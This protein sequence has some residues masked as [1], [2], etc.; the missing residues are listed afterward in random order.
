M[1]AR[2]HAS[3]CAVDKSFEKFDS[4][5]SI[6]QINSLENLKTSWFECGTQFAKLWN[7]CA[8]SCCLTFFFWQSWF[9]SWDG[10]LETIFEAPPAISDGKLHQKLINS[11]ILRGIAFSGSDAD[12]EGYLWRPRDGWWRS[13]SELVGGW[14][15]KI[16]RK[17]ISAEEEVWQTSSGAH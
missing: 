14:V 12:H 15:Q 6:Q 4:I 2:A 16:T 1:W 11:L 8:C 17:A 9:C 5:S 7:F 10:L 13:T 3:V